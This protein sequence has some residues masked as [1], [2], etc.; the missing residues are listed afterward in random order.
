MF[1]DCRF[2]IGSVL[3]R[4]P[5]HFFDTLITHLLPSPPRQRMPP[6]RQLLFGTQSQHIR[7]WNTAT[8]KVVTE[9]IVPEDTPMLRCL[10][11][12]PLSSHFASG[13]RTFVLMLPSP[14]VCFSF[15]VDGFSLW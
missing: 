10:A 1:S 8:K 7:M 12:S 5:H 15:P 3:T 9:L 2:E 6:C 4:S 11:S 14:L 13:A